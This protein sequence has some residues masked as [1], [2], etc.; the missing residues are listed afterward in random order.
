M[1]RNARSWAVAGL[2]ALAAVGCGDS[3]T[4]SSSKRYST[5]GPWNGTATGITLSL[6]LTES[7]GTI[8]G[9][10]TI[11]GTRSLPLT[12]TGT[13]TSNAVALTLRASGFHDLIFIGNITSS[14]AMSGSLNGSGFTNAS[15]SFTKQ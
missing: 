5:T 8:S 14:K 3:G 7:S 12:V 11:T 13:N 9:S 1:K 4:E 10:G 15:A 2:L 6:S